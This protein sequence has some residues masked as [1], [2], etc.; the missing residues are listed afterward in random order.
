LGSGQD[1]VFRSTDNGITWTSIYRGFVSVKALTSIGNNL[2]ASNVLGVFISTDFGVSWSYANSGLTNTNV[3]SLV[4]VPGDSG[5]TNLYAGTL[6]GVIFVSTNNGTNWTPVG[7]G[8]PD[9]VVSLAVDH[10]DNGN[11]FYAGT[12]ETGVFRSTNNG[13]IWSK[14]STGMLDLIF[15]H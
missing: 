4:T 14:V 9:A 15:M 6:A 1:G 2:F 12:P 8:I 10:S 5:R 7:N 3:F 13:S 11:I